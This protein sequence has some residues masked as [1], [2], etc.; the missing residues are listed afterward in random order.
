MQLEH[1]HGWH[2]MFVLCFS[3]RTSTSFGSPLISKI[4]VCEPSRPHQNFQNSWR[5][6]AIWGLWRSFTCSGFVVNWFF[7][8]MSSP[9]QH[10]EVN[11][12]FL[13]FLRLQMIG[14]WFEVE[15]VIS[16]LLFVGC[17]D[18]IL[19]NAFVSARVTQLGLPFRL[20][21][22]PIVNWDKFPTGRSTAVCGSGLWRAIG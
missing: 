19:L 20:E 5:E 18:N 17:C 3:Y 15:H 1:G 21:D 11:V 12:S 2:G 7:P 6:T 13:L 22:V 4:H 10:C 8:R 16:T 14:G 9:R